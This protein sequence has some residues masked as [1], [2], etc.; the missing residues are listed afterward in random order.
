MSLDLLMQN[1]S[2]YVVSNSISMRVS[3]GT[4]VKL[5]MNSAGSIQVLLGGQKVGTDIDTPLHERLVVV[6]QNMASLP[7]TV[8]S[9]LVSR[10]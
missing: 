7:I 6:L 8:L 5:S 9:T 10:N 1:I 4:R 2:S 3:E